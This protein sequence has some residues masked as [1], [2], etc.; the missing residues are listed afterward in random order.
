MLEV[1]TDIDGIPSNQLLFDLPAPEWASLAPSL[2]ETSMSLTQ[3]LNEPES[4]VD[5]V[6]FPDSG[7]ISCVTTTVEGGSVEGVLTGREGALGYAAAYGDLQWPW[8]LVVQTAGTASTIT[9]RDLA[10]ILPETPELVR[11]L[12]LHTQAMLQLSSQS[13]ACNRFHDVAHRLARWL[14]VMHDRIEGDELELTHE[15]LAHMLG[16]Y[17]PAVGVAL[18]AFAKRGLIRVTKRGLLEVIDRAGLEGA[19]CECYARIAWDYRTLLRR[20][21]TVTAP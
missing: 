16:T 20:S 15:F 21:A 1:L 2:R 12:V 18:G 9:P 17:R 19:A 14:L 4:P 8:R 11:R 5:L 13:T 10:E 6:Y 3:V 7:V